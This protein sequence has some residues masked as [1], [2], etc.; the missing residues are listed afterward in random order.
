M[1]NQPPDVDAFYQ[2]VWEIARQVP[3]GKVTTYGQI[4]S[5]IPPPEELNEDEYR[6][7]APRWVGSAM[8]AILD[9]D[10]PTIP[11][12]RVINSKGGISLSE[13][14]RSGTLQRER[15]E[16]EGILF[17]AKGYVDFHDCGWTADE[18]DEKWLS[19]KELLPPKAL[20]K[21]KGPQ[22]LSL[23]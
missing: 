17:N 7:L 18:I 16:A 2:L 19:K 10:D 4:A 5:M 14:S 22:Q 3:S 20:A 9:R 15:L 21:D 11:W 12:H 13:N 1:A 8:N 23:F 6:K